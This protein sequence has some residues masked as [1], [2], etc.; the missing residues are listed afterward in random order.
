MAGEVRRGVPRGVADQVDWLRWPA[1]A[2]VSGE[3]LAVGQVVAEAG[4]PSA[5]PPGGA[6]GCAVGDQCPPGADLADVGGGEQQ[7]GEDRLRGD[8]ADAAPGGL[9][10][11]LV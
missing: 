2:V 5:C 3:C 4:P 6:V 1:V 8:A 9:A 10:E 11:R 7:R